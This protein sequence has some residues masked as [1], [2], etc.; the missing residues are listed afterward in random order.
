MNIYEQKKNLCNGF[1]AY[2]INVKERELEGDYLLGDMGEGLPFRAGSFDGAISIR[3]VPLLYG[4]YC[5]VSMYCIAIYFTCP[6]KWFLLQGFYCIA[7]Q[8][9][10]RAFII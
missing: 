7:L 5:K 8:S 10:V 1:K 2:N 6:L 4:Y 9:I 3:Y